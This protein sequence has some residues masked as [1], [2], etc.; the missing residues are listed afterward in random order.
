MMRQT[1]LVTR[2]YY[3]TYTNHRYLCW[4]FP[5]QLTTPDRFSYHTGTVGNAVHA[6][7]SAEERVFTILLMIPLSFNTSY[8]GITVLKE[9]AN[10]AIILAKSFLT[11]LVHGYSNC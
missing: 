9:S 5:G 4:T 11:L 8:D 6:L 10:R 7:L 2:T 3:N 1:S